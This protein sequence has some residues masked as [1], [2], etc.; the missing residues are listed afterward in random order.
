MYQ[1]RDKTSNCSRSSSYLTKGFPVDLANDADIK[2]YE[3]FLTS[4]PGLTTSGGSVLRHVDFPPEMSCAMHRTV[5]IDYGV[6]LEGEMICVLDSGEEKLMKR[7]DVCIQRGTMHAWRN[8]HK[9]WARMMFV[10]LPC[11]PL[12]VGG[13]HLGTAV[14]IRQSD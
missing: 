1:R 5:S 13:E 14:G 7:G 10:L 8:P 2:T 12:E 3:P 4:P 6:I 9:E 11:V